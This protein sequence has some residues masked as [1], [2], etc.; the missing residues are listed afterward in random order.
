MS[1]DA[2]TPPRPR[3]T[4]YD[5]GAF[6][7]HIGRAIVSDSAK[8]SPAPAATRVSTHEQ[9]APSPLPGTRA[10]LRRTTT[11]ELIIEPLE[12]RTNA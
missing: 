11:D 5:V 1:P 2:P 3:S 10:T 8:P 6:L 4:W 9:P 12:P 7:G